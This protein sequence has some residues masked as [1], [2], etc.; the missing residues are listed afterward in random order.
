MH[1]TSFLAGLA[2][3]AVSVTMLACKPDYPKCSKDEHCPGFKDGK[4]WCVNGLCQQCRPGDVGKNDCPAGQQCSDGRCS[5]VPGWC[6]SND[7]C[8]GQACVNHH[9]TACQSDSQCA[10]GRCDAGRCTAEKRTKCRSNDDCAE[11]ED[12][13]NGYC[14]P[15]SNRFHGGGDVPKCPLAAVY[16]DFNESVLSAEATGLIDRNADCIKSANRGVVLVGHTDPRG[17]DEY[18]LALSERRA[19]SVRD[20]LVRLGVSSQGLSTLPR[21]ELDATGTDET[22]WSRDRRVDFQWK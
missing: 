22:G 13:V 1:K 8:G 5:K 4:E 6:D 10:G 12:C 17:T 21:G 16:F 18:N 7:E 3:L 11:S 15:A 2:L 9:C 14:V 19:Q 20:R